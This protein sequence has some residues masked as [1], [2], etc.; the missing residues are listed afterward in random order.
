MCPPTLL[1]TSNVVSAF[2]PTAANNNAMPPTDP[3]SI[4]KNF[5]TLQVGR[6]EVSDP[7]D[8][9][10]AALPPTAASSRALNSRGL[11][12]RPGPFEAQ[13]EASGSGCRVVGMRRSQE[14]TVRALHRRRGRAT[15]FLRL[16]Q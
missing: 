3:K 11:G 1:P 15:G 14:R 10:L 4:A 12:A 9:G 13:N 6:H 8:L 7:N 16:R 5:G 2:S